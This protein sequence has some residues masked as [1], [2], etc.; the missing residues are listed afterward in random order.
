[1][2]IIGSGDVFFVSTNGFH[3]SIDEFNDFESE[4]RKDVDALLID[5]ARD[6]GWTYEEYMYMCIKEELYR[7]CRE[8]GWTLRGGRL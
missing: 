3:P 1:M 7:V 6:E 5:Q 8:F 4:V 2:N